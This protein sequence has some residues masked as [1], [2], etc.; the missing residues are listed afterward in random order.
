MIDERTI[1]LVFKEGYNI[2]E[3]LPHHL[4]MLLSNLETPLF[5]QLAIQYNKN[6]PIDK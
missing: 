2:I 5:C 3:D 1:F 6:N 4:N